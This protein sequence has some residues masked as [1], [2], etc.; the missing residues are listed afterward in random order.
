[1]YCISKSRFLDI[2]VLQSSILILSF[3]GVLS[4]RASAVDFLSVEFLIYYGLII[5]IMGVY[6]ILW[7]QIIKRFEL[8]VAYANKGTLII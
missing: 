7:Q 8:S 6:A 4:K 2:A 3:A 5:F 1:M